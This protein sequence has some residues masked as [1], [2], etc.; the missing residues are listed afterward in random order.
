MC[1]QIDKRGIFQEGKHD[2][3]KV[4]KTTINKLKD[5]N[6]Q[7]IRAEDMKTNQQSL[8]Q[9]SMPRTLEDYRHSA[10]KK[11]QEIKTYESNITLK[12]G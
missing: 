4:L 6:D 9:Q 7:N 5:T 8:K 2:C 1:D 3:I 12:S 11:S 10:T